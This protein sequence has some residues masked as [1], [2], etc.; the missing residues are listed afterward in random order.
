MDDSA[1]QRRLDAIL[2]L[3]AVAVLL[4]V[5]IGLQYATETTVG[6]LM[7]ASLVAYGHLKSD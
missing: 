6:V 3:L 5:G 7:L 1:L 2:L 4:L